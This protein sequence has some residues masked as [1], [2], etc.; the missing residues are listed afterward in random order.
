MQFLVLFYYGPP[1]FDKIVEGAHG[2]SGCP[3]LDSFPAAI[4]TI[5]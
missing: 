3:R 2:N 1:P 5:T 4:A